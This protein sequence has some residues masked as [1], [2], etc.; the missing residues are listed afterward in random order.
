MNSKKKNFDNFVSRNKESHDAS[1][2]QEK[3]YVNLITKTLSAT[4]LIIGMTFWFP[5]KIDSGLQENFS[6]SLES[7]EVQESKPEKEIIFDEG[8]WK[9]IKKDN[10]VSRK[11]SE[12]QN[13]END[14]NMQA[15]EENKQRF[16][17]FIKALAPLSPNPE[18]EE[19]VLLIFTQESN[20]DPKAR[21]DTNAYG[22]AQL[23][24]AAFADMRVENRGLWYFRLLRYIK[25]SHPDILLFLPKNISQK[26]QKFPE[27][28][29]AKEWE[30][31]QQELYKERHNP[32]VNMLVGAMALAVKQ[33][34]VSDEEAE[35]FVKNFLKN[36]KKTR[37]HTNWVTQE[38]QQKTESEI[39]M[40]VAGHQYNGSSSQRNLYFHKNPQ[41]ECTNDISQCEKEIV[42]EKDAYIFRLLQKRSKD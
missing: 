38:M 5:K 41:I 20:L 14:K 34:N 13:L 1:L 18:F 23:T 21:S 31:F 19:F 4:T 16:R 3:F 27:E 29:S 9:I 37:I 24:S 32:F 17:K 40:I 2:I 8:F 33:A 12:E 10:F 28:M 30:W 6:Y 36:W 7:K 22:I 25:L 39:K 15:S 11:L 35:D 42:S 26:I